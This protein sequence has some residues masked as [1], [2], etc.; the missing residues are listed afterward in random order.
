[1]ARYSANAEY[2][3]KLEQTAETWDRIASSFTGGK[4]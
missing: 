1:M 4:H 3:A 2:R